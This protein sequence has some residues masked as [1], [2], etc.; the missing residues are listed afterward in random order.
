MTFWAWEGDSTCA[1]GAGKTGYGCF[2]YRN[3]TTNVTAGTFKVTA[4]NGS[5]AGISAEA[6]FER[7]NGAP[8]SKFSPYPGI[9]LAALDSA[10]AWHAQVSDPYNLVSLKNGSNQTLISA[11]AYSGVNS[12][13]FAW[14]QAQ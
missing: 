9:A 14:L 12:V 8:V 5:F 10:S 7:V 11:F 3:N 2:W 1:A 6:V 13:H 4:P